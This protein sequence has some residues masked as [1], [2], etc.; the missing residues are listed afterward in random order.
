MQ[1]NENP[2]SKQGLGR[3]G[4]S[5]VKRDDFTARYKWQIDEGYGNDRKNTILGLTISEYYELGLFCIDNNISISG[6][7]K[8]AMREKKTLCEMGLLNVHDD[9]T[10]T[11]KN[12]IKKQNKRITQQTQQGGLF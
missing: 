3:G 4:M 6:F 1:T 7:V 10:H 5:T 12:S 9:N 2:L 11:I 8:T